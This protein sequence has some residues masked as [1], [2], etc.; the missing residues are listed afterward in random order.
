MMGH[1]GWQPSS[2][3][4]REGHREGRER[5]IIYLDLV[6]PLRIQKRQIAY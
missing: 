3:T 4:E 1:R 6:F 5:Q 2:S